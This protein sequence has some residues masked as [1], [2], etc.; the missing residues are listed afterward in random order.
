[1]QAQF[2]EAEEH[3]LAALRIHRQ[4]FGAEYTSTLADRNTLAII[5]NGERRPA[6][7]EVEFRE[8]IRLRSRI[9]GPEHPDT[10]DSQ[11]NLALCLQSQGK[12]K[13]ALK[14]AEIARKGARKILPPN[15]AMR[16]LYEKT[17]QD[18]TGKN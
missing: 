7:A 15:D 4:V 9:L 10:L 13:E 18:L 2:P 11:C 5:L 17:Y 3:C 1:M 6:E 8:V 16:R 12:L 14:H